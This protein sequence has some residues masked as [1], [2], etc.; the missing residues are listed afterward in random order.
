MALLVDTLPQ[1]LLVVIYGEQQVPL[2]QLLAHRAACKLLNRLLPAAVLRIECRDVHGNLRAAGGDT[3][4]LELQSQPA[5]LEAG[6][7][8]S[9]QAALAEVGDIEIEASAGRPPPPPTLLDELSGIYSIGCGW[10][11]AGGCDCDAR[12]IAPSFVV[13]GTT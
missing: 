1:E 5:M 6:E 3:L 9:L 13:V 2:R 4:D 7:R 12:R 10:S 8:R 11:G